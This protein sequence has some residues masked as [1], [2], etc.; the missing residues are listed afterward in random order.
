MGSKKIDSLTSLRFFA[1]AM[2]VVFHTKSEFGYLG[3]ADR[4]SIP[5]GVSFFFVLSGFILAHTHRAI[6]SKHGL[7]EFY[8]RRIA[9]I[10]PLHIA[11]GLAAAWM[12]HRDG[13]ST[14]SFT[15]IL[16]VLLMQAWSTNQNTYFSLNGVAWSLSDEAFFYALFPLLIW[17]IAKTWTWK[18]AASIALTA[19][20][21]FI[22]KGAD[23]ATILW[24][25]YIVPIT[26]LSEFMLGIATYQIGAKLTPTR[27]N[28]SVW[29]ACEVASLALSLT[30][31]WSACTK[32][33]AT[34]SDDQITPFLVWFINC[35]ACLPFAAVVLVFARQ[36]GTLSKAL[37]APALLYLGEISFSLY[38]THE[39]TLRFL[40]GH[41]DFHA[42]NPILM[43][44]IYWFI[45]L[46]CAAAAHRLIELPSQ[47]A[48]ISIFR[49]GFKFR[50]PSKIG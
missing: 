30:V 1:A 11:G 31:M 2:I 24:A 7:L 49:N 46:A 42:Y 19:V 5:Q 33:V 38:M 21:L 29:T 37:R 26:R 25:G 22:F 36:S 48:M 4:I 16:N 6:E 41:I 43:G 10:W 8:V 32:L 34:S 47:R 50:S 23:L 28:R 45:A 15:A 27:P 18:L 35:G 39:L 40:Q 3:L 20:I 44:A 12:I 13:A 14:G 17:N 9:K